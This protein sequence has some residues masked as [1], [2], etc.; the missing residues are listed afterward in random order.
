MADM[1]PVALTALVRVHVLGATLF[2]QRDQ[3]PLSRRAVGVVSLAGSAAG[4]LFQLLDGR[5]F[6]PAADGLHETTE[7]GRHVGDVPR[8]SAIRLVVRH[9]MACS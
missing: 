9:S 8:S 3:L 4:L 2:L 7:R 1:P 5:T 6:D